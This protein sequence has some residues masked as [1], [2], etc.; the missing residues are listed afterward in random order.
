M[1][2]KHFGPFC[3]CTKGIEEPLLPHSHQ[4]ESR[5]GQRLIYYFFSVPNPTFYSYSIWTNHPSQPTRPCGLLVGVSGAAGELQSINE[6]VLPVDDSDIVDKT[7][8]LETA[9][10]FQNVSSQL[11]FVLHCEIRITT[12]RE[13]WF[14]ISSPPLDQPTF[15]CYIYIYFYIFG[16][17]C[18]HNSHSWLAFVFISESVVFSPICT[19]FSHKDVLKDN[20]C[21]PHLRESKFNWS[22]ER[23]RNEPVSEPLSGSHRDSVRTLYIPVK[24]FWVLCIDSYFGWL[25][26]VIK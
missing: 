24:P 6:K 20:D 21:G 12:T 1:L 23:H 17:F 9:V 2:L 14:F 15:L 16:T 11:F 3:T 19:I 7:E 8:D 4:W 25:D 10:H 26:F 22:R 18:N 13:L 5:R